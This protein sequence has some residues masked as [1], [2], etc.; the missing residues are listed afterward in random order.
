MRRFFALVTTWSTSDNSS[1]SRLLCLFVLVLVLV[2]L[3]WSSFCDGFLR[4][5]T[6]ISI[7]RRVSPCQNVIRKMQHF[8]ITKSQRSSAGIPSMR[9]P[10]SKEI[11]SDSVELCDTEFCL[12]HIKLI[13]TNVRLPKTHKILAEVDS[14]SSKVSNKVWVLE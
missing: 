1:L 11:T 9:R 6:L 10:A 8:Y 12:L 2:C 4:A 14:E 5:G 13:R 3:I 7:S